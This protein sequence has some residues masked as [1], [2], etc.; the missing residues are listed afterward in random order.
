MSYP[1]RMVRCKILAPKHYLS[2]VITA[3]YDLGLYHITPHIKGELDIGSPIEEA[4][5]LAELLVKIRSITS[6]FP[7][8]NTKTVTFTPSSRKK[9]IKGVTKMYDDFISSEKNFNQLKTN[10]LLVEKR[11]NLLKLIESNNINLQELQSSSIL[12]CFSGTLIKKGLQEKINDQNITI[13]QK[14]NYVFVICMNDKKEY[15]QS[16]LTELGF[17]KVDIDDTKLTDVIKA[18]EKI[19]DEEV[20]L[21]KVLRRIQNEIPV[22]QGLADKFSEE[23]KMKELPLQF[24]VTE[25]SF[26]AT[27]WI[28]EKSRAAVESEIDANTKGRVHIEFTEAKPKETPPVK[29]QNQRLVSPFEVLQRLY[30]L[31]L[32]KEIDPTSI[33]FFTFPLFFGFMLGDIGY[34]LVL[35]GGFYILKKKMPSAAQFAE[36]LMFAA[37]MSI[38]F[39]FVFG[40]FFGFEHISV[41]SGRSLCNHIGICFPEHTTISHGIE[42][43][44]ADFPRLINRAHGHLNVFGFEML[45]VLVIGAIVGFVHVNFGFILGFINELRSHGFK[46]AL[47]AKLS[48]IIIEIGIILSVASLILEWSQVPLVGGVIIALIGVTLLGIGEGIQGLVEIPA[49]VSNMLSYMRLGAVGLASVGLAVVVNENFV[50]PMIE[51]G[52][53]F[54]L[55]GLLIGIIGH[56][57]NIALGVIGPFL[58][59][60]RLHYVELFSKFF[61][62]GGMPYEPFKKNTK[63]ED[64]QK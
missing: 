55:F 37:G 63:M 49:L 14:E 50:L 28:P 18:Q 44:V 20:L 10:K 54:I 33:F 52:G 23:I 40:E 19:S 22:L 24:A 53:I 62:G 11:F 12:T 27:G 60:V 32:Y 45:T 5:E 1:E 15:V 41:E 57:I 59:S 9:A 31:P 17:N 2:P 36:V 48:W 64:L 43:T 51:K 25:S 35:L 34:G 42:S 39:G 16:V 21:K 38:I 61:H 6:A 4:E 29:L 56:A 47:M 26:I 30:D 13:I 3:L 8:S 58:H 7:I 46:H